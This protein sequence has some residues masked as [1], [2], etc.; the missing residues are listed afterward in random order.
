MKINLICFAARLV[1]NKMNS[2]HM[3]LLTYKIIMKIDAN[4][5]FKNA[6]AST[7]NVLTLIL[8]AT[9]EIIGYIQVIASTLNFFSIVPYQ[10]HSE[11]NY[12]IV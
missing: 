11:K 7:K 3:K 2:L 6:G 1:L 10:K 8:S 9:K 4:D 12:L 5:D